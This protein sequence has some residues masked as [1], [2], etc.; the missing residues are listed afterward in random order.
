MRADALDR[1]R[2]RALVALLLGKPHLV[3]DVHA[4]DA[5]E[6]AVAVE[7][8]AAAIVGLRYIVNVVYDVER[9]VVGCFAG[10]VVAAHRAGCLRAREVYGTRLPT[11]ADIVLIDSHS[12]D[13]DFWETAKGGYAGERFSLTA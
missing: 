4:V 9:R 8:N 7:V 12:A 5:V 10:D 3:T 13:R 1:A 11:R 6:H 2:L